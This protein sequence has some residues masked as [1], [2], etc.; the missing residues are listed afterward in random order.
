[1]AGKGKI[2]FETRAQIGGG[3]MKWLLL[4]KKGRTSNHWHPDC[5]GRKD[6]VADAYKS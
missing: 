3:K 4:K 6:N 2:N 1:M 5:W